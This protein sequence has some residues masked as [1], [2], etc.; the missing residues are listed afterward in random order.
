MVQLSGI[1]GGR[2]SANCSDGAFWLQYPLQRGGIEERW[3]NWNSHPLLFMKSQRTK[4][5]KKQSNCD[6]GYCEGRPV[7]ILPF[8][9]SLQVLVPTEERRIHSL[10]FVFL[11]SPF[12]HLLIFFPHF[13]LLTL[14]FQNRRVIRPHLINLNN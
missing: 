3:Y 10:L 9:L 1:S 11:H 4:P 2:E 13:Q 12:R 6:L 7:S 5:M 8:G 14:F